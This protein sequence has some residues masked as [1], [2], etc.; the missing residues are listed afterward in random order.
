MINYV[1]GER[2]VAHKR[3]VPGRGSMFCHLPGG[4]R[5]IIPDL[6]SYRD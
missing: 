3:G 2:E 6:A 1:K 4:V 5:C